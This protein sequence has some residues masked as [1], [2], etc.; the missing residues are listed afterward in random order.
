MTN[1]ERVMKTLNPQS[2]I[3]NPKSETSW[4]P[5]EL[6]QFWAI[7]N[8]VYGKDALTRVYDTIAMQYKATKLH[9]LDRGEFLKLTND[10]ALK[11]QGQGSG[12]RGQGPGKSLDSLFTGTAMERPWRHIRYL[13]RQL[14]WTELHLVNYIK[15]AARL[16]SINWL[17]VDRSRGVITGMMKVLKNKKGSE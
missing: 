14:G 9:E 12:V 7:A 11:T 3:R 2:E 15:M 16:D 17:S 6:R 13:Q 10:L 4:S 1:Q 8:Q 5:R